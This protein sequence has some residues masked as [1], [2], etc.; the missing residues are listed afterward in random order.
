MKILLVILILPFIV[1]AA[2]QNPPPNVEQYRWLYETLFSETDR[3]SQPNESFKSFYVHLL[4]SDQNFPE[5]KLIE[6][7]NLKL[8]EK[9]EGT[10]TYV[11]AIKK[12]YTYGILKLG[13][14]TVVLNVRIHLKDPVGDDIKNFSHKLKIAENIWNTSRVAADFNYI[15]KFE[16]VATEAESY[17]SVNVLDSTRGPYDRNWSRS[18]TD[19]VI[20]HEVGHMLGLGDEYQ[21][22]SGQI[23][24]LKSSLMCSSWAGSLMQHHYYFILRRLINSR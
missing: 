22:L 11:N 21:T 1:K 3:V 13:D 10:I 6:G 24:C 8:I 19:V 14:G 17:F 4:D 7:K 15:F 2:P 12:K 23:D 20:A 5:P 16:L 18:W 9:V